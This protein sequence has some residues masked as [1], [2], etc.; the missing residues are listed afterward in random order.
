MGKTKAFILLDQPVY[1]CKTQ[2]TGRV[3]LIVDDP[4]SCSG[5]NLSLKVYERVSSD[6]K[7][8]AEMQKILSGMF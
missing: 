5:I 7:K 6:S 1:V 8:S 4:I 3:E 2:L